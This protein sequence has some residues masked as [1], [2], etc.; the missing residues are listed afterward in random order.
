MNEKDTSFFQNAIDNAK[1]IADAS[2]L[3]NDTSLPF[4][5]MSFSNYMN[6]FLASHPDL[7]V[8]KIVADSGLTRQYGYDVINGKKNG[9][10]DKIIALCFSC[11]MSQSETDRALLYAKHSK[12]YPRD[13]K[14]LCIIFALNNKNKYPNVTA[15]NVFLEEN[16]QSPLDV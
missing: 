7:T 1:S 3:V 16:K 5:D 6:E 15:L 9:S 14:D 12:L 10:R 8:A 11:G 4:A 2:S 13:K